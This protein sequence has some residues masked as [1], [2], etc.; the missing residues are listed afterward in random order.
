MLVSR[1]TTAFRGLMAVSGPSISANFHDLNVRFGEKRTL[2]CCFCNA[3][4][5]AKYL[6]VRTSGLPPE[7]AVGLLLVLRAANDCHFNRSTQHP[8]E[9]EHPGLRARRFCRRVVRAGAASVADGRTDISKSRF[10]MEPPSNQPIGLSVGQGSQ[11][12]H[13]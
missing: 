13:R 11:H 6:S 10:A 9:T 8:L 7:P 2:H 12:F 4:N 1:T 3:Q 5:N